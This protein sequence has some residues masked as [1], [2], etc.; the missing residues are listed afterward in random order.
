MILQKTWKILSWKS[1]KNQICNYWKTKGRKC[2]GS[3]KS[4]ILE[5]RISRLEADCH[6]QD[7]YNR[8]NNVE[9][10]GIPSNIS[11]DMLE[12]NVIQ[13]FEGIALS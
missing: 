6:K 2:E 1:V 13:I 8:R 3:T 7:Q 4:W 12:E 9:I 5:S 11:D 10:P